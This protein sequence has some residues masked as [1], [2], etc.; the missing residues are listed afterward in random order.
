MLRVI[1]A[2]HLYQQAVD[3]VAAAISEDVTEQAEFRALMQKTC[4]NPRGHVF[5]TAC[6]ETKCRYCPKVAWT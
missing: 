2:E 4:S 3:A 5:V 6:G 1:I